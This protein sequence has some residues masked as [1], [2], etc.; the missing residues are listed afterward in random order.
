M[1]ETLVIIGW[2]F[3][4]SLLLYFSLG[5]MTSSI[6]GFFSIQKESITLGKCATKYIEIT[7]FIDCKSSCVEKFKVNSYKIENDRCFCDLNK[8]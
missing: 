8:C 2:F 6:S 7:E 3:A 4:I 5:F 1:K